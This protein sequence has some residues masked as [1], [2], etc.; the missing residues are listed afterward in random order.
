MPGSGTDSGAWAFVAEFAAAWTRPLAPGDGYSEDVLW[1]AG[2]R[3]APVHRRLD[4]E[5]L[6][7]QG[8]EVR[9]EPSGPRTSRRAQPLAP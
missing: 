1:A 8:R 6:I 5:S 2:E 4:G 7:L 9:Q 3:L